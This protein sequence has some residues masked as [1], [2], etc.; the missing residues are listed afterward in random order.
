[1]GA[2]VTLGFLNVTIGIFV[3]FSASVGCCNFAFVGAIGIAVAF[4]FF[5]IPI[6][7]F[8]GV[9][10]FAIGCC[11]FAFVGALGIA[12]SVGCCNFGLIGVGSIAVILGFLNVTIGI[13]WA[14]S[15]SVGCCNFG[16]AGVI[17]FAVA[18]GFFNI[19]IGIVYSIIVSVGCCNV[20]IQWAVAIGFCNITLFGIACGICNCGLLCNIGIINIGILNC[21]CCNIG[22]C[23]IGVMGIPIGIC[24]NAPWIF[25]TILMCLACTSP[26]WLPLL[27]CVITACCLGISTITLGISTI[28]LEPKPSIPPSVEEEKVKI[29][30]VLISDSRGNLIWIWKP[31]TTSK[32]ISVPCSHALNIDVTVHN[33]YNTEKDVIVMI[34]Y[35]DKQDARTVKIK[36]GDNTTVRF[37]IV[38]PM[39]PGKIK[40]CVSAKTVL[41]EKVKYD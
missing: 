29:T 27:C 20:A 13:I 16:F 35:A 7:I 12:A 18:I 19:T 22:I 8:D 26:I 1:M 2:A 9:F 10:P 6:G 24:W 23:N 30:K 33:G 21:G 41:G 5:N 17:G 25:C 40:C 36:E 37:A 15:I 31:D 14:Y 28:T 34:E 3:V 32:L 39:H 11:N 38:T 4:G